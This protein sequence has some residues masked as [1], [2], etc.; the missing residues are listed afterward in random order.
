VFV[1]YVAGSFN[2]FFGDTVVYGYAYKTHWM[3][4]N[5]YLMD[6]GNSV[7]FIIWKDYNCDTWTTVNS[8]TL[9]GNTFTSYTG[10]EQLAFSNGLNQYPSSSTPPQYSDIWKAA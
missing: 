1:A 10:A 9:N 4:F 8:N 3:W 6:D 5:G 7:G 2:G